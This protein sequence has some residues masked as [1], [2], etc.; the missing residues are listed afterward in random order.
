MPLITLD[1]LVG[2]LIGQSLAFVLCW[3]LAQ[4]LAA[5]EAKDDLSARRAVI[6]AKIARHLPPQTRREKNIEF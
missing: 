3:A 1:F 4:Y 6:K 5:R 2:L